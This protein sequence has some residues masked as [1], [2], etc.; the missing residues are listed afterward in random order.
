MTAEL[1]QTRWKI[2]KTIT[3]QEVKLTWD[4][5]GNNIQSKT[6]NTT[7]TIKKSN[8]I[9]FISYKTRS[10]VFK[11]VFISTPTL[12]LDRDATTGSDWILWDILT[13][14][15]AG[16]LLLFSLK[17][18]RENYYYQYNCQSD[19][20]DS[21]AG[22]QLFT[23]HSSVVNS[24]AQFKKTTWRVDALVKGTAAQTKFKPDPFLCRALL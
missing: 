20:S 22:L 18:Q 9:F 10:Q 24:E 17:T 15:T 16:Q 14:S 21:H 3:K 4:M 13:Q 12:T 8:E 7:Y 19:Q 23:V 2:I 6:G 11:N 5:K 1:Q